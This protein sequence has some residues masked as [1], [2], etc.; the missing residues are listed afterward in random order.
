MHW[1]KLILVAIFA[2][3]LSISGTA[4][5]QPQAPVVSV[6]ITGTWIDLSWTPVSRGDRLY[7]VLCSDSLHG[8]CFNRNDGYGDANQR[9]RIFLVR[10]CLLFGDPVP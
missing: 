7:P 1:K 5:S 2:F 10:G 9:I 6:Q 3:I 8:H 4:Q